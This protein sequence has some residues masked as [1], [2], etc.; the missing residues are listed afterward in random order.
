MYNSSMPLLW[1]SLNFIT[2][3]LVSSLFS[4]S[5]IIWGGAGIAIILT[6]SLFLPT[7]FSSKTALRSYRSI[8]FIHIVYTFFFFF[9]AV[10][11]QFRQPSID[12]SQ[13]AFYN[14]R[15]YEILVTGRLVEPPDYR[16]TYTNLHL[17]V[18]AVDSGSGDL[19]TGGELLVRVPA[20]Q[21]YEYSELIR[22]R[23]RL[24][25]PPEDDDFSY[26]EY[27]AR[28]YIYSYM[29]VAEVTRLPWKTKNLFFTE[30][31]KL[32]QAL[33]NNTYRLYHD[34]EASLLAGILFG[35]DTGL[36]RELQD[37]FKNTGTAH[38]IAISGFNIAIIAGMFFFLFKPIL[39][40]RLGAVAAIIGISFYAFLV[41]ADAAV[42]R[43]TLMGTISLAARQLG[44]RNTGLNALAA[45][46]FFM[47]FFNPLVLWDVGFQLSFFATLG[48]ILYAEPFSNFT[49]N[50]IS[51]FSK[52][53]TSMLTRLINDY[54]VLTFAAQLTTI[55]I[56]AYHFK[57]I[58]LISFIAN[59]FIL[60]V[61][62]AV[63]V[64]SGLAVF[65]SLIIY[66]LGQLLAW[67]AW[68]FSTY[69][70]RM[71]EW[72][73]KVPHASIYLGD[74]S[75]WLVTSFY[76]ALLAVTFGWSAIKE[77]FS[78]RREVLRSFILTGI[79]MLLFSCTLVFWRSAETAGD[80]EFHI[81]FLEVGSA[82]A[83]LIQTPEGRN[84]L[85]NGGASV[86]ELS[87]ELGRRLPFFSRK[88]D[89]LVIASTQENQIK[90]LPRIMERYPPDNVLWSG[91]MQASF[92]AQE[93]D[94]F[95]ADHE[96]PITR[97]ES[98]Q[99]LE[100]GGG[101]FIEI[102]AAGPKGSV[103]LIEYK[104][105]RALLPIGAGEDNTG[106]INFGDALETKVDVLL[107]ADS[108]YAPSNPPGL[109]E[110]LKPQLVV[111]S[112]SAGDPDGLPS[113]EV[114]EALDGY[115]LLRTDR[116]GWITVTTDGDTMRVD[117]ERGEII[118]TP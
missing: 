52:S 57:R 97:A 86:S 2:G 84:V 46:A 112:V 106:T 99:R 1:I 30:I 20:N 27:L 110:T 50:I 22:V 32:K 69:T 14:D 73:D 88:L 74:S 41:G 66:P 95:F 5:L 7:R 116:N 87:D 33:L 67:I 53:D 54:F 13:V 61:Q 62:P 47:A 4:F 89:W 70:I 39:G 43:A 59:P 58:S 11:Y 9:G 16:D 107:L 38:I 42:I 104:N 85:I 76:F 103:I 17:K 109:I 8:E 49:S 35:V 92:A 94:K 98:G 15:E 31:Y 93:L 28:Q 105:F 81:T 56:M 25:T 21:T 23:G 44:R 68:P 64:G 78:T 45:V 24:K 63:M 51:K 90:A 36:T 118:A 83:V 72:F 6:A 19:P 102:Q 91:N 10:W 108:G 80:G 18:E 113:Q 111:L 3:I 29:P 79:I 117:V 34:P 100:L 101:A 77:W 26:R 96:I 115:S 40:E 55:P 75:I 71:V 114:L 82:D 37:A 60:P 48:L 12:A 65:V